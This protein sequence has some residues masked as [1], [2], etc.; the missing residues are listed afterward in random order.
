[1]MIRAVNLL[2]ADPYRYRSVERRRNA[3]EL[4]VHCA[5]NERRRGERQRRGKRRRPQDDMQPP[6]ERSDLRIGAVDTQTQTPARFMFFDRRSQGVP[7]GL[8]NF[9][10]A[11]F[12]SWADFD[13]PGAR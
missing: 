2:V 6:G 10:K 12:S 1:M 11:G 9:P 7:G 8:D 13:G 4:T 5:A 3:T